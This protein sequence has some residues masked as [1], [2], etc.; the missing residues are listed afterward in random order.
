GFGYHG[1][2]DSTFCAFSGEALR[3][4]NSA[5]LPITVKASIVMGE[6]ITRRTGGRFYAKSSNLVQWLRAEY[7]RA[8]DTFDVLV[9]PTLLTTAPRN[10]GLEGVE[11]IHRA[12]GMAQNTAAFNMTGHP[13]LAFPVGRVD[14][15]PVSL[16]AIAKHFDEPVLFRLALAFEQN[17]NWLKQ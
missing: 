1:F 8:L 17:V 9:I 4:T 2:R 11:L 16:M 10:T 15:L 5:D 6:Y 3:Q 14:G 7:D 12:W 13:A